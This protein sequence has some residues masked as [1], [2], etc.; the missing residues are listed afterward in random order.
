MYVSSALL[1]STQRILSIIVKP[2]VV[3]TISSCHRILYSKQDFTIK[4]RETKTNRKFIRIV[5]ISQWE[6][7]FQQ[8]NAFSLLFPLLKC[9]T[10]PFRMF[11]TNEEF[12]T[13]YEIGKFDH[14]G[15]YIDDDRRL[16]L[17]FIIIII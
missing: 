15:D 4:V 6:I 3:V 7:G 13:R 8:M 17:L 11:E 10:V 16:I 1:G 2:I 9:N 5:C 12:Y 14:V